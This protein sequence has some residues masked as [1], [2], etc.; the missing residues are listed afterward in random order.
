MISNREKNVSTVVF[1][2]F[3]QSFIFKVSFMNISLLKDIKS[4]FTYTDF[5]SF[6]CMKR[7]IGEKRERK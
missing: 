7:L 4:H 2:V 5:K 3:L 1:P 6:L